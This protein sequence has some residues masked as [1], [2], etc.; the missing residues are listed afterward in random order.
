MSDR[1]GS[2]D[3]QEDA[4]AATAP[5]RRG[6]ALPLVSVVEPPDPQQAERAGL[7][8]RYF[9][10]EPDRAQLG[11]LAGL[12]DAGRLRPIVGRV[13]DLVDGAEAFDAKQ[14]GGLPGK[15]VLQVAPERGDQWVSTVTA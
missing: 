5:A 6:R 4:S 12:I 9:I 2:H 14:G 10:V 8:V 7:Q 11:K 1:D 13:F 15:V 3:A